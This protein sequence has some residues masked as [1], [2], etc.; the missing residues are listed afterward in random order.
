VDDGSGRHA[1]RR[2]VDGVEL[3]DRLRRAVAGELC[4]SQLR[5]ANLEAR[6]LLTTQSPPVEQ[7]CQPELSGVHEYVAGVQ[8]FLFGEARAQAARA[9]VTKSF[10]VAGCIELKV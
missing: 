8:A 4:P 7:T 3:A 6:G 10:M 1:V 2:P 5:A 9:R